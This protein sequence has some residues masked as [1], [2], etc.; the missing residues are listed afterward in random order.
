[1]AANT[2]DAIMHRIN[3]FS[4]ETVA[5]ATF[6]IVVLGL[7]ALCSATRKYTYS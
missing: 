5:P 1:M 4:S 7:A 3:A 2:K 6:A